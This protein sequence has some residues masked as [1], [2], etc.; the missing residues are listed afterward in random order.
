MSTFRHPSRLTS[1]LSLFSTLEL[2]KL[3]TLGREPEEASSSENQSRT[4]TLWF[5]DIL[6]LA[7]R[8]YSSTDNSA[9]RSSDLRRKSRTPFLSYSIVTL[10]KEPTFRLDFDGSLVL[11]CSGTVSLASFV[12]GL[13]AESGLQTAS[14]P[15]RLL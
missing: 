7:R 13:D 14:P 12:D 3:N 6:S 10:R 5:D 9:A 2:L 15:I 1:R 4:F 8:P 11:W